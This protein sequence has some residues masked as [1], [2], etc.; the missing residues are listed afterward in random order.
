MFN[1]LRKH[2]D[3]VNEAQFTLDLSG[4][5]WVLLLQREDR[6]MGFSTFAVEESNFNGETFTVLFSGD[7]IVSPEAWN[8]TAL[9]RGW[10]SAVRKIRERKP[11]QRCVWLLLTSGFRT[12]RF[13]PVFWREFYP[14]FQSPVAKPALLDHLA[15]E[16]FGKQYL[17]KEGVVRFAQ[18]QRLSGQLKDLP[19]GRRLDPHID[20]F[21]KRNPGWVEGD[22]LVCL[23]ELRDANLTPAGRRMLRQ[24]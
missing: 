7:T 24:R 20:F 6:L 2:F 9:S 21:L 22:E 4:K 14:S 12:Y 23:T 10:I 5:N 8:S 19:P 17:L 16:R 15:R 1:L 3:G 18:P 11:F 13:L